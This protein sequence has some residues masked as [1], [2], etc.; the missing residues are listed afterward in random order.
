MTKL[1]IDWATAKAEFRAYL[2]ALKEGQAPELLH[3]AHGEVE[4]FF[5]INKG[6]VLPD[7]PSPHPPAGAP[8]AGGM[9]R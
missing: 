8:A 3:P 2:K 9:A 5:A 6:Q 1:G 7:E 4:K